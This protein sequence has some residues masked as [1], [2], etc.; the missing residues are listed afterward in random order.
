MRPASQATYG[1]CLKL[2]GPEGLEVAYTGSPASSPGRGSSGVRS[3]HANTEGPGW[4]VL[5]V[6]L[7]TEIALHSERGVNGAIRE[8]F[9]EEAEWEVDTSGRSGTGI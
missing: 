7:M 3:A 4:K 5:C 2:E 8:G 9:K 6:C 1:L